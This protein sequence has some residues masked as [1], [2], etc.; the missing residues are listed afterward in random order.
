MKKW[1]RL[2]AT[3]ILNL[4]LI[5]RQ[6][7]VKQQNRALQTLQTQKNQPIN[8]PLVGS[9]YQPLP[10]PTLPPSCPP[11]CTCIGT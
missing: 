5:L 7:V 6:E 11:I 9:M 2:K 4:G 3:S 8:L 10:H 1:Q